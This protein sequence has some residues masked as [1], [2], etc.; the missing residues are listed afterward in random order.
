MRVLVTA[1]SRHG[2]TT[3]IAGAIAG[4]LRDAG[5]VVDL[6]AP[7]EVTE[8]ERYDAVVLG[9]AV[10]AGRWVDAARAF[11]DRHA[12]SLA[13]R[14]VWLFSSGPIGDPPKPVEGPPEVSA[15]VERLGAR[16]HRLF[17]GRL[18]HD[19]LGFLERAVT[20]ALRAPDGDFRDW[21]AIGAWAAGIAADLT[22]TPL[23]SGRG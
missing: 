3:D 23:A 22:G 4:T 10:Y 21:D 2:A 15:L 11:A 20:R 14:P 13:T 7:D 19:E 12:D 6:V 9:S 5:L 17:A 8:L 1:A 18:D 16:D